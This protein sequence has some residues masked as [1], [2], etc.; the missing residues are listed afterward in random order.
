M[1]LLSKFV[2]PGISRSSGYGKSLNNS[3][4]TDITNNLQTLL[5][6]R[7]TTDM[8]QN[9][10]LNDFSD[11]SIDESLMHK[12]CADI[13][14]QIKLNE[15]RLNNVSVEL[16]ENGVT[17]WLLSVNATL[18]ASGNSSSVITNTDEDTV[19][20]TLEV[21]KPAYSAAKRDINGVFL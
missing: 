14:Q 6:S 4:M 9:I 15:S 19:S 13:Q 17:R 8:T 1:S 2:T 5:Q 16:I 7:R 21:A 12:L 11:L 18:V 20:F 10:G 3:R